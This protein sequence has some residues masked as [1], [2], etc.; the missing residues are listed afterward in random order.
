VGVV[1]IPVKERSN[2]EQT[3][4]IQSTWPIKGPQV[5]FQIIDMSFRFQQRNKLDRGGLTDH[6]LS[7][8]LARWFGEVLIT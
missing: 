3:R 1:T 5:H 6:Y 4:E 8:V 7:S 2:G